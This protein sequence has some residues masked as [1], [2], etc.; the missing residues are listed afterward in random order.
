[1]VYNDVSNFI[2]QNEYDVRAFGYDP[3][4][5]KVFVDNWIKYNGEFGVEKVPQGSRTESVPLGELKNLA[6]TRSLIFDEEIMR[7]CMG[8]AITL[9]DTNGN[10]KLLKRRN[11]AKIDCVASTMDAWIAFKNNSD[12][13]E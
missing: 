11:E 8:N 4:N 12:A 5:S 3:Y 2:D 6:E 1:M 10:K 9:E 7:F 13:F